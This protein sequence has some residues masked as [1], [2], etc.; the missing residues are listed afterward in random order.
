MSILQ[1]AN[2][3]PNLGRVQLGLAI[4]AVVLLLAICATSYLFSLSGH[5]LKRRGSSLQPR[6]VKQIV[7]KW[8]MS[9]GAALCILPSALPFQP[10]QYG[11]VVPFDLL[12]SSSWSILGFLVASLG[13]LVC[14]L[15]AVSLVVLARLSI[16][17]PAHPADS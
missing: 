17:R 8:G 1:L 7:L 6:E 15:G 14:A 5:E 10:G 12:T 11:F 9:L 13:N 3:P 16:A 2:V 4:L